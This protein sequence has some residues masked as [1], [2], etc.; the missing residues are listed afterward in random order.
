MNR[1]F[2]FLTIFFSFLILFLSS[3]V[4]YAIPGGAAGA[5]GWSFLALDREQWT[6]LHITGG[7]LFL[8]FGLWHTVLNWRG[9]W[10][11]LK[12]AAGISLKPAWPVMAALAL[13]AFIV[14][15][16]LNH[17]QPLEGI[18]TVY[19]EAKQQFHT[20]YVGNPPRAISL[21]SFGDYRKMS[22]LQQPEENTVLTSAAKSRD[23]SSPH[24]LLTLPRK[25]IAPLN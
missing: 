21:D 10:A 13:N 8:I 18:L 16:T 9:L 2:V 23:K 5:D 20:G 1:K 4:L 7:L 3:F 12:K 24:Y 14:A 25:G 17:I 6:D 19:K 15:G 22:P 11:G